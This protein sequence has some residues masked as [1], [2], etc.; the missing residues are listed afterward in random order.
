[1]DTDTHTQ[2]DAQ[3]A[4]EKAVTARGHLEHQQAAVEG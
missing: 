4:K 3:Q 2:E 1:M